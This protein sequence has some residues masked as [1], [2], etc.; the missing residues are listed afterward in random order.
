MRVNTKVFSCLLN[1]LNSY[2]YA[3]DTKKHLYFND[4]AFSVC[5]SL[6]TSKNMFSK[7]L[8]ISTILEYQTLVKTIGSFVLLI[9]TT[10]G[11]YFLQQSLKRKKRRAG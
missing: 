4:Y 7:L 9:A 2:L 6:E 8:F 3:I 1:H 10:I 5:F 11:L